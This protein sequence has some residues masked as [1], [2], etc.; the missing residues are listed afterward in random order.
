MRESPRAVRRRVGLQVRRLRQMREL[1]Q[2]QLA[3][4]A[5]SSPEHIG[6]VEFGKVD[7]HIDSLTKIANGLSVDVVD[8]FEPFPAK[9]PAA[10]VAGR[11]LDRLVEAGRVAARLQ[12]ALTR[13][14]VKGRGE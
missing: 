10:L 2:E 4:K 7:V 5:G 11:D 14:R 1:S 3:E 12:K 6:Q 8:L 9:R 13:P